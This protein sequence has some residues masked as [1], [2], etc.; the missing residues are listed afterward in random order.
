M[1]NPSL[2]FFLSFADSNRNDALRIIV[3][4]IYFFKSA[5]YRAV[6]L[7]MLFENSHDLCTVQGSTLTFLFRSACAQK[8]EAPLNQ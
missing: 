3:Y 2:H 1:R 6:L 8:L 7:I 5:V 4:V